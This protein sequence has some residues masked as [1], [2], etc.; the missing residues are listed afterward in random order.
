MGPGRGGQCASASFGGIEA[1]G[2]VR[3]AQTPSNGSAARPDR[4][5]MLVLV[6][7]RDAH[8]RELEAHFLSNAGYSVEFATDGIEALELVKRLFSS[9]SRSV[10]C[11]TPFTI[12]S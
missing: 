5:R 8:I 9:P 10:A 4:G 1:V 11:S 2:D 3:I 12:C 7:E 6:V